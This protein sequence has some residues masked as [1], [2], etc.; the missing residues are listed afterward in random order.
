MHLFTATCPP[1]L[2]HAMRVPFPFRSL[3]QTHA[4]ALVWQVGEPAG[5]DLFGTEQVA[6]SVA[7]LRPTVDFP[8]GLGASCWTTP[9]SSTRACDGA[10][11]SHNMAALSNGVLPDAESVTYYIYGINIC[12][13]CAGCGDWKPW[14]RCLSSPCIRVCFST[15]T[16]SQSMGMITAD[17]CVRTHSWMASTVCACSGSAA[18]PVR[19]V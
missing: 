2:P 1:R 9:E 8:V 6:M 7:P 5:S 19:R 14:A 11:S 17:C 3:R 15:L 4:R 10:E 16:L 13:C 18:S 12:E